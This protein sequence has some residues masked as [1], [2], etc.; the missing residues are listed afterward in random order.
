MD[1][2]AIPVLFVR[3]GQSTNN[4]ILDPLSV[5]VKKG[6]ISEAEKEKVWLESRSDDPCL[7]DLGK[8]E[9]KHLGNYLIKYLSS[10]KRIV[11]Y[12][13][14][15]KRTC[16][17][18]LALYEKLNFVHETKVICHPEI[19]ESGGVYINI[20]GVRDGPGKCLTADDIKTQY[21]YNVDMLPGEGQWYTKSWENDSQSRE[22][23]KKVATWLRSSA[24][25]KENF[26]KLVIL[27]MHGHFIDHLTKALLGI[28][29]DPCKDFAASNGAKRQPVVFKTANTATSLFNVSSSGQV[30]IRWAG[31]TDHIPNR[32]GTILSGL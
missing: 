10:D 19:Y 18:T 15:F 22:R 21:G 31:N 32:N 6:E 9:A 28:V 2:D 1:K 25:H 23:A 3:H 13:S 20:N 8:E 7:T 14:P 29:D 4:T 27:V 30:C 12:T 17:T 26:G 11:I 5:K 24:F 16:D